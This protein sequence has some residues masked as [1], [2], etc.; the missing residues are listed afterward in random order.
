MS[1]RSSAARLELGLAVGTVADEDELLARG[2]R[3]VEP[4]RGVLAPADARLLLGGLRDGHPLAGVV[5]A[6]DELV[7]HPGGREARSP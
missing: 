3:G 5:T 4:A 6:G 7:D 1:G 2:A